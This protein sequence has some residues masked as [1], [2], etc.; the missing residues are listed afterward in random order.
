MYFAAASSSRFSFRAN[1][2]HRLGLWLHLTL[3][4]QG[5][6]MPRSY[7]VLISTDFGAARST[8]FPLELSATLD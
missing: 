8:V 6:Y 4:P 5:Q 1:C 2:N 3:R 7:H